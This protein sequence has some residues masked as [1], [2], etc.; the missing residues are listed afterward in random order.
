MLF[1]YKYT[2]SYYDINNTKFY[3]SNGLG[4][5]NIS[6]RLFNKPSINLY[7]LSNY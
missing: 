5:E 7:R 2:N 4:T 3:I 1:N 6:F